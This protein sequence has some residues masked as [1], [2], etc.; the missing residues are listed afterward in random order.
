M[1]RARRVRTQNA[2]CANALPHALTRARALTVTVK[3]I[4]IVNAE[5]KHEV[6]QR[7]KAEQ[8]MSLMETD[9]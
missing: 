4:K 3:G 6:L 1:A 8:A 9:C 5:T 7:L 2:A